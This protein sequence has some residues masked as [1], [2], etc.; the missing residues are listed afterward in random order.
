MINAGETESRRFVFPAGIYWRPPELITDTVDLELTGAQSS[1]DASGPLAPL[2]RSGRCCG[3]GGNG[4]RLTQL[5]L[6][7]DA[8]VSARHLSFVETG[9]PPGRSPRQSRRR[10]F[11]SE[12]DPIKVHRVSDGIACQASA[13]YYL[14][15]SAL[16]GIT[17]PRR[18]FNPINK[19]SP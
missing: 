4:R 8:G 10:V 18:C 9:L 2:L 7:L 3:S 14:V 1:G 17:V 16:P 6:A 11:L 19:R 13:R 12:C 15:W 5:E